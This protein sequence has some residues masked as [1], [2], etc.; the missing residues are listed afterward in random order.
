MCW[1]IAKTLQQVGTLQ[2]WFWQRF[3]Q[4][5]VWT[6]QS[7]SSSRT[8]QPC[9]HDNSQVKHHRE[10]P[11]HCTV[12]WVLSA[13]QEKSHFSRAATSNRTC[14]PLSH[15]MHHGIKYGSLTLQQACS[16]EYQDRNV[17]SK[18]RWFTRYRNSH[19]ISQFAAF[20]IDVGAK[21]SI[22]ERCF[23]HTGPSFFQ[24]KRPP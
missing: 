8:T 20:F 1:W 4:M 19:Y 10:Q 2:W 16:Q 6:K 18:I 7:T 17:R 9:C 21:T 13:S 12:H 11:S 14:Q 5:V 15:N 3:G 22:A 24:M 23:D